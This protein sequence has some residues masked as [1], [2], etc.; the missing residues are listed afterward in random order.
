MTG[1]YSGIQFLS[2]RSFAV[3]FFVLFFHPLMP[4]S[5]HS[6]LRCSIAMINY[7][8]GTSTSWLVGAI[9]QLRSGKSR[10]WQWSWVKYGKILSE[11]SKFT[12]W[13]SLIPKTEEW[14]LCCQRLYWRRSV[15]L[16]GS[17]LL[18]ENHGHTPLGKLG[19]STS[20]SDWIFSQ[21]ITL[22]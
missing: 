19:D 14:L 5:S 6:Q 1:G 15:Y 9:H 17:D 2:H 22:R 4:W 8:R 3:F 18:G 20:L 11:M 13:S 7:R 10:K 12:K 21:F 16:T